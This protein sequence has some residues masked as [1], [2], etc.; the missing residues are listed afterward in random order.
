MKAR[1]GFKPTGL[2]AKVR[3]NGLVVLKHPTNEQQIFYEIALS[4]CLI[5]V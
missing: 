1:Q 3:C 4:P 2:L 5:Y